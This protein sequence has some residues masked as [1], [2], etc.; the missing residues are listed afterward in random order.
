MDQED[1]AQASNAPLGAREARIARGQLVGAARKRK[2]KQLSGQLFD[3]GKEL[4]QIGGKSTKHCMGSC[5]L[6]P[7]S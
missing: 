2:F 5:A 6:E 3:R 1:T 7:K 4:D